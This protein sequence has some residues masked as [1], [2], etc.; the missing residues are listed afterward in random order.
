[1]RKKNKP[2]Q[3][4][5]GT[6]KQTLENLKEVLLLLVKENEEQEVIIKYLEKRLERSNPV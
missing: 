4:T 6:T 3:Q 5:L 2:Q 1:M